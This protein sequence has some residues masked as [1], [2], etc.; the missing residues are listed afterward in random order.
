MD[1]LDG[2]A[3]ADMCVPDKV[4]AG[5]D[6]AAQDNNA[7]V[8]VEIADA[9]AAADVIAAPVDGDVAAQGD[10]P[11]KVESADTPADA[12]AAAAA[13]PAAAA[14]V[15]AVQDN[16][17]VKVESAAAAP[18]LKRKSKFGDA[19]VAGDA[20]V[21][22]PPPRKR[23][24]GA[25][26]DTAAA[27]NVVVP[28][29]PPSADMLASQQRI[30][31]LQTRLMALRKA[32]AAATNGTPV[33]DSV[34]DNEEREPSPVPIYGADGRR[35]N[36][37]EQRLCDQLAAEQRCLV[38]ATLAN[39]PV[40]ALLVAAKSSLT[41]RIPIP[42]EE[43]PDYNFS[44]VLIGPR[45]VNQKRLQA[46]LNVRIAVRGKG[47]RTKRRD[48]VKE[49][50]DDMPMHVLV[51]A[52]DKESLDR[53][54]KRVLEVGGASALV[55]FICVLCTLRTQISR[56][57][58]N[59]VLQLLVP[60]SAEEK[61]RQL[62]EVAIMNGTLDSGRDQRRCVGSECSR[63]VHLCSLFC[64]CERSRDVHLCSL[65]SAHA[66][67]RPICNFVSTECLFCGRPHH[68]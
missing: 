14:G 18:T 22:A 55:S 40:S 37:R 31:A 58:C 1:S 32:S 3:I 45:G 17:A 19:V 51:E 11:V 28:Q 6:A 49:A 2:D 53:A 36:T 48:G 54:E 34:D 20:T 27:N 35:T 25:A 43:Y 64:C 8:E 63:D 56:S 29:R 12:A 7:G 57:I 60:V 30:A 13:A 42:Q 4:A 24:W 52:K 21:T 67:S 41:L 66:H 16:A 61:R 9:S 62:R 50:S 38:T 39:D 15:H 10:A 47:V 65:H 46:E 59:S 33:V 23:R 26:A 5:D 44:G 68:V